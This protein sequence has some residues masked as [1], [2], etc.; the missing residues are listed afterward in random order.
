MDN[1]WLHL[2]IRSL[3]NL[4]NSFIPSE[5]MANSSSQRVLLFSVFL[6]T[7]A[8]LLNN[9]VKANVSGGGG[10]TAT[11]NGIVGGGGGIVGGGGGVV[12]SNST[13]APNV[14]VGGA[15]KINT[16]GS[17]IIGDGKINYGAP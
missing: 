1:G 3:V 10:G 13:I 2:P 5:H 17:V 4:P 6:F 8:L 14:S 7:S 9:F 12:E 15:A 11:G 16:D